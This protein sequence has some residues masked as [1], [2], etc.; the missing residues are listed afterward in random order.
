M[1]NITL[2]MY[3][4]VQEVYYCNCSD[5]IFHKTG[6]YETFRARPT[7]PALMSMLIILLMQ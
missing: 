4:K 3:Q 1:N 2:Q 7:R 5:R 6:G